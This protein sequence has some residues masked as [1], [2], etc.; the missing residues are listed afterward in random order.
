MARMSLKLF[1]STGYSSL[2]GAGETRASMHPGWIVVVCSTWAGFVCNV[3]LWREV[4]GSAE[5]AGLVQALALGLFVTAACAIALS[6]LAW[7]RTLKPASTF[8]L[9]ASALAACAIWVQSIPINDTLRDRPLASL[10]LPPWAS[11]LRWQ[12]AVLLVLLA[13]VPI[14][15]VW[16]THLRRL[17][18]PRQLTVNLGAAAIAAVVLGASAL[19]LRGF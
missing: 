2:L 3:A 12:V 4:G 16:N 5:G 15:W 18:G 6:L 8:V 9:V 7:R 1:R 13:A 10:V 11:L 19:L 17:P 14:V